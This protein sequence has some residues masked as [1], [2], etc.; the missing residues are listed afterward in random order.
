[1]AGK[2]ED[3]TRYGGQ[4]RSGEGHIIL[5][6][7]SDHDRDEVAEAIIRYLDEDTGYYRFLSFI[8]G[9]IINHPTRL[10]RKHA[11]ALVDALGKTGSSKALKFLEDTVYDF[12]ADG[13]RLDVLYARGH[14]DTPARWNNV[15]NYSFPKATGSVKR[16]LDYRIVDGNAA[17]GYRKPRSYSTYNEDFHSRVYGSILELRRSLTV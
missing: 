8:T 5:K 14:S 10:S 2:K 1:M 9:G 13:P 16:L 6:E 7:L 15:T 3:I 4:S 11:G 12:E 17:E